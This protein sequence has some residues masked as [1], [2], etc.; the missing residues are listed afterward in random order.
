MHAIIGTGIASA[1][2]FSLGK[3]GRIYD[4]ARYSGGRTSTKP[5]ENGYFC[6]L[7]ASFYRDLVEIQ[8]DGQNIGFSFIDWLKAH[9]IHSTEANIPS[10]EPLYYIDSGMQTIAETILHDAKVY[11]SKE[12]VGF[13]IL[14]KSR[15]LLQFLDGSSE[16]VSKITITTPL[17]Q[18]LSFFPEGKE[19]NL[20]ENFTKKYSHYR[21]TL[22]SSGYWRNPD[23][24]FLESVNSLETKSFL[25]KGE[26]DEYISLES[27]KRKPRDIGFVMMIQFSGQFS[28]DNFDDWRNPDRSPTKNCRTSFLKYFQKFCEANNL[29]PIG[30]QLEPDMWRVHKWKYGMSENSMM[31]KTGIINLDRPEYKEYEELLKETNIRITGDWLFGPR[32]ERISAGLIHSR[33]IYE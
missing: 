24:K 32:M 21:K 19:K 7:G 30:D 26:A 15:F 18:A 20:W 33:G 4:K 14:S 11:Y 12:L 10:S 31:G 17:P 13:Q 9:G 28:E 2:L 27:F 3:E 23:S 6:D 8:R 1:T 25:K 29:P 5:F 16:E 22:V